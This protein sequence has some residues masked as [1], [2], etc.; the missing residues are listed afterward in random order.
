VVADALLGGAAELREHHHRNAQ[1][2]RKQLQA[3]RQLADFPHPFLCPAP[4]LHELQ[5]IDDHHGK[6]ILG[7]QAPRLTSDFFDAILRIAPLASTQAVV[8]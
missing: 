1:F 2:L 3:A 4:G 6:A 7:L 8:G 5:V